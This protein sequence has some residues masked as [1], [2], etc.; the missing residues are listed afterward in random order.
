MEK[1]SCVGAEKMQDLKR[2]CISLL[3]VRPRSHRVSNCKTHAEVLA[4]LQEVML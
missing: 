3:L 2:L 4:F 1:I